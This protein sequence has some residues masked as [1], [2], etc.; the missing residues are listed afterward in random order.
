MYE[1]SGAKRRR[2]GGSR[3]DRRGGRDGRSG[4]GGGDGATPKMI[5]PQWDGGDDEPPLLLFDLNGTLTSH[6]AA[7]HSSGITRLRPCIQLLRRLQVRARALS[8]AY[9]C[10]F[11]TWLAEASV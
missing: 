5:V 11:A 3:R 9:M 10:S 2:A 7:R 1:G 6:T 4:G 8:V